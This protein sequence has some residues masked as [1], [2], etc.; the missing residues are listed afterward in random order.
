VH[1]QKLKKGWPRA[2]SSIQCL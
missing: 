1:E 2:F